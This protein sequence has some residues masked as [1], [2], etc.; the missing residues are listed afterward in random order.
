MFING[1]LRTVEERT[2]EGRERRAYRC[3]EGVREGAYGGYAPL[4]VLLEGEQI[5][6]EKVMILS[7]C[8][9]ILFL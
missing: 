6:V 5:F 4:S 8:V 2:N 9:Y 7:Y 3:P 1:R